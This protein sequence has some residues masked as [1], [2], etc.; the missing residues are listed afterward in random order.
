MYRCDTCG[1]EITGLAAARTHAKQGYKTQREAQAA[2]QL[3]TLTHVP[4]RPLAPGDRVKT[5]AGKR[6]TVFTPAAGGFVRVTF[7]GDP[8][9]TLV[10]VT[11]V[12]RIP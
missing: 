6:G 12:R 5:M 7:D 8:T 4:P 2:G 10:D 3:H 11:R 1:A 9:D